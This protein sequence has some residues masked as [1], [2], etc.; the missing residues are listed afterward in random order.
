MPYRVLL[1]PALLFSTLVACRVTND[2]GK[3]CELVTSAPANDAGI[4]AVPITEGQV[5]QIL[6][7]GSVDGGTLDFVSFGATECEDFVCVRDAQ[8][9]KGTDLTA[10]AFGYCSRPCSTVSSTTCQATPGNITDGR[11]LNCRALTLTSATI[12]S[13]CNGPNPDPSFCATLGG[14]SPDYCAKGSAAATGK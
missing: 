12:Q 13:I 1:L 14:Q 3:S 2:L 7:A 8:A 5:Q 6:A 10:P 4:L 9:P 11:S